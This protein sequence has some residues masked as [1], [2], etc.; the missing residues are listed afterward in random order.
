MRTTLTFAAL[1]GVAA[2]CTPLQD[3]LHPGEAATLSNPWM[4]ADMRP[5]PPPLYCYRTLGREDC[6]R[7]PQRDER[8]RLTGNYGPP[9]EA[10]G[11]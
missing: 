10:L 7:T 4:A 6:Y 9:P 8:G 1:L 11:Y 2:G 5:A 3:R